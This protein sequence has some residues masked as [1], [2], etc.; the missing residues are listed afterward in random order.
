[1][2]ILRSEAVMISHDFR[3]R[4][5]LNSDSVQMILQTMVSPSQT[6]ANTVEL[7]SSDSAVVVSEL[8]PVVLLQ[9]SC[10]RSRIVCIQI[11]GLCSITLVL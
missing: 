11:M 9:L 1:M 6:E 7:Y 3:A 5:S 2:Y 4:S 10:A 8:L